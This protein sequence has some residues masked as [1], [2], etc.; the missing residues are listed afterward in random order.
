MPDARPLM[1]GGGRGTHETARTVHE[2]AE[3]RAAEVVGKP[4]GEIGVRFGFGPVWDRFSTNRSK[5]V[6]V[7]D[8]SKPVEL[9][10]NRSTRTPPFKAAKLQ[11]GHPNGEFS[12]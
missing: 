1:L 6:M 5:L 3:L 12:L 2:T 10:R 9:G 11:D 8:V 4:V 7:A